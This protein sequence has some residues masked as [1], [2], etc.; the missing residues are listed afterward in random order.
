[1]TDDGLPVEMIGGVPVVTA[2]EEVDITNADGLRSALAR[3]AGHGSRTLVV[4]MSRT[5]F[6]DTAGLHT[7]VAAHKRA[8]AEGGQVLLVMG[9]A[10]VLRIFAITGLDDVIPYFASLEQALTQARA[11]DSASPAQYDEGEG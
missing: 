7:L 10:A 5:Q 1:V 6:C 3:A 9:G 2:P 4:D 8:Q 11:A